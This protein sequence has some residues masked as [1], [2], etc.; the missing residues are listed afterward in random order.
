MSTALPSLPHDVHIVV[1]LPTYEEANNIIPL[2]EELLAL[3]PRLEV[4]V[5][6]DDSPDGTAQLVETRARTEPPLHL[7][8]RTEDRGRG[9]SRRIPARTRDGR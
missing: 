2:A 1:T 6:D 8:L 9:R 5:I 3:S 7:L 4:L